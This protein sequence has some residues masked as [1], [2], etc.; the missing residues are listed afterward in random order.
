[1]PGPT[2]KAP[3]RW[4]LSDGKVTIGLAYT[5]ATDQ[6]FQTTQKIARFAAMKAE[7]LGISA[8]IALSKGGSSVGPQSG[9][10]VIVVGILT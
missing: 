6:N 4:D 3:F 1:M 10:L 5:T 2:Q 8:C 9:R 7:L